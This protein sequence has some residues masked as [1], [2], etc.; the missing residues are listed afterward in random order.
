MYEIVDKSEKFYKI[1]C[2]EAK[3]LDL[4]YNQLSK[5][6]DRYSINSSETEVTFYKSIVNYEFILNELDIYLFKNEE[7]YKIYNSLGDINS[8]ELDEFDIK[9]NEFVFKTKPWEHQRQAFLKSCYK[10]KYAL[11]MEQRTGKLFPTGTRVVTPTGYT[12]IENIKIGDTVCSWEG[13]SKVTNKFYNS[14]AKIYRITFD[15]KDSIEC[16]ED[17]LWWVKDNSFCKVIKQ[18]NK[19]IKIRGSDWLVKS[20]KELLEE[21]LYFDNGS[22]VQCKRWELPQCK[23]VEFVEQPLPVKPYT[24][25][26]LIGD[27]GLTTQTIS[28]T[29]DNKDMSILDRIE[30]D[31]YY[32]NRTPYG[33]YSHRVKIDRDIIPEEVKKHSYEKRIPK[34]YLFNTVENRI[35]LLQGLI[36]TDSW[37]KAAGC[38]AKIEDYYSTAITYSTS[39]KLLAEDIKFLVETLG[40]I[41]TTWKVGMGSYKVNGVKKLTRLQYSFTIRLPREIAIQCCTLKRK[42]DLII[43][44]KATNKRLPKRKI[45]SIDYIGIKEGYCLE[46]DD[47]KSSYL[48]E[49]CL[50]THNTKVAL[51]TAAYLYENKKIE[52]VVIVAPNIVHNDWIEEGCKTHL[53]S[54]YISFVWSS[55]KNK[56]EPEEVSH[57]FFDKSKLF[58]FSINREAINTTNGGETLRYL[59]RYYKCLLIVDESHN[60][61]NPHA[62]STGA[63]L[64]MAKKV[65]YVRILSGT[66]I[67]NSLIDLYS[68]LKLLDEKILGYSSFSS[69]RRFCEDYPAKAKEYIYDKIKKYFIRVTLRECFKDIPPM[70]DIVIKYKMTDK[71]KSIYEEIIKNNFI[72]DS[73]DTTLFKNII[74]KL[75]QV[76]SGYY[77]DTEGTEIEVVDGKRNPKIIALNELIEKIEGKI[78]IWT[79][80]KKEVKD[81]AKNLDSRYKYVIYTGE[82][83]NEEKLFAKN[84][85]KTNPDVKIIIINIQSGAEGLTLPEADTSIYYSNSYSFLKRD[86]SEKRFI[87]GNNNNPKTCYN[88]CSVGTLDSRILYLLKRKKQLSKEMIDRVETTPDELKHL[89]IGEDNEKESK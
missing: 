73:K 4:I 64:V 30:E 60:F 39:S 88:L 45:V 75:Q 33:E 37:I 36:D 61:K 53:K 21:G 11:F 34:E 3:N 66:P 18:E 81:V 20:T 63:L 19:R 26:A 86:Q 8:N 50:V 40:G 71:Q 78:I 25:G 1:V 51:D 14:N 27:G 84:Q 15:N 2:K 55:S 47:K 62:K 79:K 28:I 72:M 89:I 52:M 32:V 85:F 7:Y 74:I 9:P 16:C 68:Q 29:I 48:V 22:G 35:K 12:N 41:V 58:I 46:V 10:E 65:K 70:M 38:S 17:H 5:F 23:P 42:L 43:N 76:V 13:V 56:M 24:L 87:T 77:I 49:N 6:P 69:F 83:S 82:Q 31:G 57:Y 59:L 54:D 44:D 80:F 67:G